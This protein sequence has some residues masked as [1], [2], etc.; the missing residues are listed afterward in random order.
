MDGT[1]AIHSISLKN[2]L[3]F[4]NAGVEVELLPLN[5]LV[6]PNGSGKS[7]FVEIF[8]L[9]QASPRD[10]TMPIIE[11][12]DRSLDLERSKSWRPDN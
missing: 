8:R 2:I 4:G 6:G 5:I 7:N 9:L 3:S 1:R 10:L 12:G 11:G